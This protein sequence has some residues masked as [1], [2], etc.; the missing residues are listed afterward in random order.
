MLALLTVAN[1]PLR[2][3]SLNKTRLQLSKSHHLVCHSHFLFLFGLAVLKSR[4]CL[5][6][7]WCLGIL[8]LLAS[9]LNSV[10]LVNQFL[11]LYNI[12][13]ALSFSSMF[14]LAAFNGNHNRLVKSWSWIIHCFLKSWAR[15][16][17]WSSQIY[18]SLPILLFYWSFCQ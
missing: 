15:I 5:N 6:F 13:N 17:D 14:L 2:N 4:F 1:G 12:L 7:A 8:L 3:D 16:L 10:I 18:H 11:L 9:F